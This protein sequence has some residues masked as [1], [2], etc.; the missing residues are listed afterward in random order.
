MFAPLVQQ[1]NAAHNA[2]A[3]N[4]S[5]KR[6]RRAR[7]ALVCILSAMRRCVFQATILKRWFKNDCMLTR[8]QSL[9]AHGS[10]ALEPPARRRSG[11]GRQ[12]PGDGAGRPGRQGSSQAARQHSQEAASQGGRGKDKEQPGAGGS[13]QEQP[14]AKNIPPASLTADVGGVTFGPETRTPKDHTA[15]APD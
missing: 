10:A 11:A 12:R 1:A 7:L 5:A 14:G 8:R 4:C 3:S 15:S 6:P 2:R 9:A 13:T